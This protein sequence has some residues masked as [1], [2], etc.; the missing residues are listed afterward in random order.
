[1]ALVKVT[2]LKCARGR[3][4][5]LGVLVQHG[6]SAITSAEELAAPER[7]LVTVWLQP[8]VVSLSFSV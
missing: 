7:V 5:P 4:P 6:A 3:M 1:M 8:W 2:G